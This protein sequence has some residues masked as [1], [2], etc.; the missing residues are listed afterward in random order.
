MSRVRQAR[1]RRRAVEVAPE[2]LL[3]WFERFAEG[4]G[5][6]ALTRMAPDR[7]EVRVVDA[8]MAAVDVPFGPLPP[9]HIEQ[10]GLA[11]SSLVEHVRRPRRIGLVL[12]R[13]GAHSVGIAWGGEIEQSSTGRHLVPG[14]SKAGGWS[15]RRFAR[16][17][18]SQ[19]RRALD[20]AADTVAR[21]L[22]PARERLDA[23]VLGGDRLDALRATLGCAA[24]L[25]RPSRECSTFPNRDGRC[26]TTLS[27]ERLSSRCTS[28][29]PE[30]LGR[31]HLGNAG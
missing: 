22:L 3:R 20:A 12:V 19:S 21:V 25:T 30:Q 31:Q 6:A 16:R 4:H 9:P 2:R 10:P 17:R 14:R 29:T 13:L 1:R 11:V 15:Q 27:V 23:I 8:A 18:D 7:V 5:G 26:S 28:T 24:C